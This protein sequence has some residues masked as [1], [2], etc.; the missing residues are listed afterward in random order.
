MENK[1]EKE[2]IRERSSKKV[3]KEVEKI[4]VEKDES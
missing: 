1:E 2:G 3:E 4:E